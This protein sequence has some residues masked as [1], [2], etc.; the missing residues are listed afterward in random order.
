MKNTISLIFSLLISLSVS[1]GQ[2]SRTGQRFILMSYNTENFFDTINDPHTA[3]DK[4]TPEGVMRW[5][6]KRYHHKLKNI[7][8]VI[9]SVSENSYPDIVML[10]EIE[11][12]E[13][14]EDLVRQP[15]IAKAH[16]RILH[17]DS[18]DP[19]GIDNAMLYRKEHFRLLSW[20]L[21]DFDYPGEKQ[22]RT[23]GIIYVKGIVDGKDTLHVFGNHWK[24]RAGEEEETESKRVFD[25]SLLKEKTD[26]ILRKNKHALIVC[27]G[28]FNDEPTN[29]SLSQVLG[30]ACPEG[31]GTK[32]RLVNLMCNLHLQG[33]GS[34][35][36]RGKWL[37]FDN[38]I[39]S[40][41]L[42]LPG[43]D[44]EVEGNE[45]HI[46]AAPWLL[47]TNAKTGVT[48]PFKTY[49]GTRYLGGYSD[50]LPIFAIFTEK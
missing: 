8:R 7:A 15:S 5:T 42:V 44:I 6:G 28:D 39:V 10:C 1:Q 25:A 35:S 26:S 24:S 36:Y 40:T 48:V 4:F 17:K 50:H 43:G 45:G 19:R 21:I 41:A 11:N 49:S 22:K 16:Y 46:Y 27:M 34:Y 2:P 37:M 13:V 30:A 31:P 38:I 23:R 29:T 14:L 47:K 18:H 32:S 3:D 33:K 20:R 9:G 12:R